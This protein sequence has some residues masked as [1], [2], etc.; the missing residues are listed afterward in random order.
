[1]VIK[2]G[3]AEDNDFVVREHPHVSRHHAR[4][5]RE[6]DDCWLLEDLGST[7]GTF[8]NGVQIVKKRVALKDVIT[9]GDNYVLDVSEVLKYNNDYSE[10]F[11]ALKKVYDNYIQAKI[12]IQSSNQF[13]TRLF[14]SLPFAIPG[15]VG[16]V[17]GFL[18]KGSPELFGL[19]LFITVCAPTV[20]IYL[21]A[22]QSAKTPQ[23]LQDIANQFKIDYVCPKCGTFLGEIPWESLRNRKQCP[24][25]SCKAKWVSE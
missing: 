17:I 5:I 23:L 15:V 3:K 25:S 2:I 11:A 22:K 13:K 6:D 24:V 4:L 21:G 14:Q 18:G 1:M 8:V 10:E 20:G 16:V 12:K 9:L 7:N 19:S